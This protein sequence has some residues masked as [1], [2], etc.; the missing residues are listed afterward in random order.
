MTDGD[1]CE[2]LGFCEAPDTTTEQQKQNDTSTK[3]SEEK[4]KTREEFLAQQHFATGTVVYVLGNI[5]WGDG[6]PPSKQ[7]SVFSGLNGLHI[8]T[9]PA[10]RWSNPVLLGAGY[11]YLAVV[12]RFGDRD[13]IRVTDAYAGATVDGFDTD[14]FPKDSIAWDK[15][16]DICSTTIPDGAQCTGLTID[17]NGVLIAGYNKG[18]RVGYLSF[19]VLGHV[20]GKVEPIYERD[21]PIKSPFDDRIGIPIGNPAPIDKLPGPDMHSFIGIAGAGSSGAPVMFQMN[22]IEGRVEKLLG[23]PIGEEQPMAIGYAAQIISILFGKDGI[24][25]YVM[26]FT[27]K[28]DTYVCCGIDSDKITPTPQEYDVEHTYTPQDLAAT[29]NPQDSDIIRT[30]KT[31]EWVN[32]RVVPDITEAPKLRKLDKTTSTTL[33]EE[34]TQAADKN[35]TPYYGD[36]L[37]LPIA[38]ITVPQNSGLIFFESTFNTVTELY[39]KFELGQDGK[40]TASIDRTMPIFRA[41]HGSHYDWLS[42]G[43]FTYGCKKS[44]DGTAIVVTD[45]MVGTHLATD[46][47]SESGRLK[48][49]PDLKAALIDSYTGLILYRYPKPLGYKIYAGS[50]A[51]LKTYPSTKR[52]GCSDEADKIMEY[53]DGIK[54]PGMTISTSYPAKYHDYPVGNP[55]GTLGTGESL[56]LDAPW[57]LF[58]RHVITPGKRVNLYIGSDTWTMRE[59]DG[60]AYAD[61][62]APSQFLNPIEAGGGGLQLFAKWKPTHNEPKCSLTGWGGFFHLEPYKIKT[63]SHTQLKS[64]IAD[65]NDM[66]TQLQASIDSKQLTTAQAQQA[67]TQI[68]SNK[69]QIAQMTNQLNTTDDEVIWAYAPQTLRTPFNHIGVSTPQDDTDPNSDSPPDR[70][71]QPT[72]EEVKGVGGATGLG[73]PAA[74]TVIPLGEHV[75]DTDKRPLYRGCVI[76]TSFKTWIEVNIKCQKS[77]YFEDGVS[78]YLNP[79]TYM[80]GLGRNV[81]AANSFMA[82]HTSAFG[83]TDGSTYEAGWS[84]RSGSMTHWEVKVT[85]LAEFIKD[86]PTYPKIQA[87][88]QNPD[89]S[90]TYPVARALGFYSYEELQYIAPAELY[91]TL[92][93]CLMVNQGAAAANLNN[94]YFVKGI[95]LAS[96]DPVVAV[97][98]ELTLYNYAFDVYRWG[99]RTFNSPNASPGP[100]CASSDPG[101]FVSHNCEAIM[102]GNVDCLSWVLGGHNKLYASDNFFDSIIPVLRITSKFQVSVDPYKNKGIGVGKY[103]GLSVDFDLNNPTSALAVPIGAS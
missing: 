100:F 48:P 23:L 83:F 39:N 20:L 29:P 27:A 35:S 101:Y 70:S 56:D 21:L 12:D 17:Y 26:R 24:G 93:S 72:I 96:Y 32:T 30:L 14:G 57:Q 58:I 33:N 91:G 36:S 95:V 87:P 69:N 51:V 2:A 25:T 99:Y 66:N 52:S 86:L 46:L 89:C 78:E 77:D 71:T 13:L 16:E 5:E 34:R 15:I 79:E 62:W 9:L 55:D 8:R 28:E 4:A 90:K 76:D 37:S 88:P 73:V 44:S 22:P 10:S 68:D 65:L 80:N 63:T 19:D 64:Q 60:I 38:M 53:W 31:A 61:E 74:F 94:N 41:V 3:P 85:P 1:F 98:V 84:A 81:G 82:S 40:P 102:C 43:G 6:S 18:G 45:G 97:C 92:A 59:S 47:S 42:D 103:F 54:R 75:T 67:Q 49:L 7:V 11:G 50:Y